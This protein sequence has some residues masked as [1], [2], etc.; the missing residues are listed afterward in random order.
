MGLIAEFLVGVDLVLHRSPHLSHATEVFGNSSDPESSLHL[1]ETPYP[2]SDDSQTSTFVGLGVIGCVPIHSSKS[3][4]PLSSCGAAPYSNQDFT[5]VK[6]IKS[7]EN[8][9]SCGE[10]QL[11]VRLAPSL[12]PQSALART[13]INRFVPCH[14]VVQSTSY[15]VGPVTALQ[16]TIDPCLPQHGTRYLLWLSAMEKTETSARRPYLVH[17]CGIYP[18]CCDFA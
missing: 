16:P 14:R 11:K 6:G 9:E 10:N 17:R 1:R 2:Q 5:R 4:H 8:V 3:V 12:G 18:R 15:T 13:L 7:G